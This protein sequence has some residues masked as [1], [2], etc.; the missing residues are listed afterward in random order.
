MGRVLS[1]LV[2]GQVFEKAR[3]TKMVGPIMHI[4]FLLVVPASIQWLQNTDNQ[5]DDVNMYRFIAYTTAIT[6]ISLLLDMKTFVDWISGKSPGHIKS[7]PKDEQVSDLVLL[8]PSILMGVVG[9]LL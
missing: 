2:A 6:A 3:F 4:P 9:W 5:T 7:L 1:F 8:A